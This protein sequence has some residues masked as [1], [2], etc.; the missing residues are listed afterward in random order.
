[1]NE[2]HICCIVIIILLIVF[3]CWQ[4]PPSNC[5]CKKGN[6]C[7]CSGAAYKQNAP[8]LKAPDMGRAFRGDDPDLVHYG[9]GTI[10]AMKWD[11]AKHY[12]SIRDLRESFM[13]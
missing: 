1:M 11:A 8:V 5:G 2:T 3:F 9:H 12:P 7:G 10:E 4:S 6:G 13:R